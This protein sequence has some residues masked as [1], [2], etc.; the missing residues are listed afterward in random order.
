MRRYFGDNWEEKKPFNWDGKF[1]DIM[2]DGGFDVVIGN[3]PYVSIYKIST[4]PDEKQFFTD[5]FY[6]AYMKFD[7]YVLFIER[8]LSLLK[9]GGL[10]A[11]I[12]PGNF[13]VAPYGKNLRQLLVDTTKVL[14]I[15]DLMEVKVFKEAQNT[16]IILLLQKE[17]DKPKRDEN[18]IEV[19]VPEQDPSELNIIIG[20]SHLIQ[21]DIFLKSSEY[22]FLLETGKED[23][24]ILTKI[25]ER[26]IAL[27]DICYISRGLTLGS[28]YWQE[29][30]NYE[31]EEHFIKKFIKGRNIKPYSIEYTGDH[32]VYKKEILTS[33]FF[34]EL[35]EN[36]KIII[37]KISKTV[38]G[39]LDLVGYYIDSTGIC[40][41]PYTAIAAQRKAEIEKIER[42]RQYTL[43]YILGCLN[44]KVINYYFERLFPMLMSYLIL[45]EPSPFAVLPLITLKIKRRMMI[46][47]L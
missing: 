23:V 7:L 22:T 31:T 46:W 6:T 19:I 4:Q 9:N 28:T 41:L 29:Y 26:S 33:A 11:F 3:P 8:A 47:W 16:P 34:P 40:C 44:S 43:F 14:Q 45:S 25:K 38:C 39:G 21:Q 42:S 2:K 15:V 18:R 36:E 24:N 27:D 30:A 12:V 5:R 17:T 13:M 1:P 32:I 20:K 35:F 37:P 10:F